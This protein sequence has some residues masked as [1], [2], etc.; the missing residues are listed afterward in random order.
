M[1]TTII[2]DR[3]NN[4]S[5]KLPHKDNNL[6]DD[7]DRIRASFS[8]IDTTL[9]FSAVDK[10]IIQAG[11]TVTFNFQDG[12][13]QVATFQLG[14]VTIEIT[15]YDENKRRYMM[16]QLNGAGLIA[17]NFPEIYWVAADGTYTTSLTEYMEIIGREALSA[18]MPTWVLV[19]QVGSI[20]YGKML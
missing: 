15:G 12:E 4:L 16:L 10:G 19:W 3:T 18:T 8:E 5:L 17:L 11:S 14:P 7:V 13:F 2:D 20:I 6:E 1:A 9:R